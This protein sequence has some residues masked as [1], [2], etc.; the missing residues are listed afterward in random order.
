[1]PIRKELLGPDNM[2]TL[3]SVYMVARARVRAGRF[4][5]AEPGAREFHD[6]SLATYGAEH[7]YIA[8]ARKLLVELYEG[9]GKEEQAAL[10]R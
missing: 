1:M 3:A 5:E 10:W 4:A 8:R 9:W 6:R 2:L 7:D